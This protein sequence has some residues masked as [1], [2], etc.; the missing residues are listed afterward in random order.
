MKL[1]T[2]RNGKP[3]LDEATF[4]KLLAAAYVLQQH[5]ERTRAAEEAS[6]ATREA[7]PDYS[8]TLAEIVEIQHQILVR[9]LDLDGAAGF[10]VE[11]LQRITGASGAA[12][13]LLDHDH[14]VYRAVSGLAA[15]EI[16]SALPKARTLSSAVLSQGTVLRCPNVRV[17]SHIDQGI[18]QKSGISSFAAVPIFH[19]DRVAGVLELV[20]ARVGG[21]TEYDVHTCQMMAGLITEVLARSEDEKWKQN[22]AAE[23]D[24][25]LEALEKLKPQ[26]DRLAKDA[27]LLSSSAVPDH[28]KRSAVQAAAPPLAPKPASLRS[29]VV[30][31]T[32]SAYSPSDETCHKCGNH[33]GVQEVYC[34]SCGSLRSERPSNGARAGSATAFEESPLDLG[35]DEADLRP[36]SARMAKPEFELP[37]E[38]LAL[39]DNEAKPESAPDIADE[40]LKLLPPE[41]WEGH[42]PQPA[43]A[44]A[45]TG[46]PWTSAANARAWLNS[47]SDPKAGANLMELVRVHRGDIS[48]VAAILL[49]LVA[50]FWSRTDR[51]VPQVNSNISSTATSGNPAPSTP[52]IDA[53]APD[54]Q[55]QLSFW[56]RALIAVGLAEPPPTPL[57]PQATGNPEISV[58]VDLHTA[59]YY[60]PGAELYGKSEKGRY[61]TQREAQSERFEPASGKVCE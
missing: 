59:L 7:E 36:L 22:L 16:G 39:V 49:V 23:R 35:S 18:A 27:E 58:W 14:L 43:P 11:N 42:K 56:D 2:D 52:Q 4:Q 40:L 61:T 32:K 45:P 53:A 3:V 48:L 44:P 13:G 20:F 5:Q 6:Q 19:D 26:L 25:M 10:V 1:P 21:F 9:K 15:A 47:M 51:P 33:L 60:C 28:L 46:Y 54:P 57:P 55:S 8:H 50:F 30:R 41:D 17:E 34:G 24:S 38:V 31:E 37:P 12:V 29:E